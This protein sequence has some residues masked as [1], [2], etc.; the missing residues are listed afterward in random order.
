MEKIC[1][2]I[3]KPCLEH[4]C[5]FYI[6]LLGKNP[7]TGADMDAWDCSI[8][9]L[10]VLLINIGKSTN[11]VGAAV[12]SLRNETSANTVQRI[13]ETAKLLGANS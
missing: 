10:P 4:G 5:K 11:E 6:H 1:P 12:E 7:Q 13:A 2:L 9:F 3:Q 8:A